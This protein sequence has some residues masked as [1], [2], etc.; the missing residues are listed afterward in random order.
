MCVFSTYTK[1]RSCYSST[2]Y[3]TTVDFRL[4]YFICFTAWSYVGFVLEIVIFWRWF[5]KNSKRRLWQWGTVSYGTNIQYK[6]VISHG[7]VALIAVV[8]SDQ[9]VLPLNKYN[10]SNMMNSTIRIMLDRALFSN[11]NALFSDCR[12]IERY[13]KMAVTY[14]TFD[15]DER[16]VQF[17]SDRLETDQTLSVSI[18]GLIRKAGY[19]MECGTVRA[20]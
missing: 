14:G 7:A 20:K 10:K 5:I 9:S 3:A 16:C 12:L 19:R 18:F 4:F 8:I 15:F 13:N 1:R 17:R 11:T 6:H 2:K